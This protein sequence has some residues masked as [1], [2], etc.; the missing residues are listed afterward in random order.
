MHYT[1]KAWALASTLAVALALALALLGLVWPVTQKRRRT[2]D[3]VAGGR[4][5][6]EEQQR[7]ETRGKHEAH[8]QLPEDQLRGQDTQCNRRSAGQ[9]FAAAAC[10]I[11]TTHER[12][13]ATHAPPQTHDMHMLVVLLL[14]IP[15]APSVRNP[16]EPRAEASYMWTGIETP[17]G[18]RD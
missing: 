5:R 3:P 7:Q 2:S 18:E 10:A 16:P 1:A 11:S 13:D 9:A 17:Q 4:A 15:R 14:L 12:N 6:R 8:S